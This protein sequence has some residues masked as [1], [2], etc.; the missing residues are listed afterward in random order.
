[1]ATRPYVLDDSGPMSGEGL[2]SRQG[3]SKRASASRQIPLQKSKPSGMRSFFRCRSCEAEFVGL[4]RLST[5]GLPLINYAEEPEN[6]DG[7]V[8]E[9]SRRGDG[10]L[11][12]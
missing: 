3:D 1:M 10:Q 11:A 9:I 4:R 8:Y 6:G 7:R 5:M 12:G 2:R